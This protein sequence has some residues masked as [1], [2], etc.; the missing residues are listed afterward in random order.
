MYNNAYER[1]TPEERENMPHTQIRLTE[2]LL[3]VDIENT[4]IKILDI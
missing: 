3:S 2:D 1:M 4:K